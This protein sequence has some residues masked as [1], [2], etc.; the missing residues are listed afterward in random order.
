MIAIVHGSRAECFVLPRQTR[1]NDFARRLAD[2]EIR[3]VMQS[4]REF[5]RT[6]KGMRAFKKLPPDHKTLVV[7]SEGG[8]SSPHL[9]PIVEALVGRHNV[10][11]VYLT[12]DINDTVLNNSLAGV[13]TFYIGQGVVRTWLFTTLEAGFLLMTM[14]Y[15]ETFHIKRSVHPVHYIYTH[16]SMVSTHMIY[17]KAAF[18]HFDTVFCVGPHHVREIRETE[19][20]YGL[21]AK[22]LF[23]HGYPR[24]DALA[25]RAADAL[26]SNHAGT[27]QR[28]L[29]APSWGPNGLLETNGDDLVGQLLE[30]GFHV[31]VRPHPMTRRQAREKLAQLQERFRGHPNFAFEGDVADTQSL[32]QADL[33][34]SDWSGAALEYAFCRERPVLFVDVPRKVNNPDWQEIGLEPIEASIRDKIGMIVRPD[35]FGKLERIVRDLIENNEVYRDRIQ[36]ARDEYV[37]NYRESANGAADYLAALVSTNG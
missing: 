6:W 27:L 17:R 15:L 24:L 14:P 23:H 1:K 11:V 8:E 19:K 21:K 18:D 9:M 22:T 5:A 16:H 20:Q 36:S 13:H 34:V 25:A 3:Y 2:L 7:Y 32:L 37:Y 35:E 10:P 31:T 4:L 26:N 30:L 29:V 28:I 33:M 12:S